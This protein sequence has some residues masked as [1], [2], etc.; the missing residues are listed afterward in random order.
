[1]GN[2]KTLQ[3]PKVLT[4]ICL[5]MIM[6]KHFQNYYFAT[7]NFAYFSS[8]VFILFHTFF[9]KVNG[10]SKAKTLSKFEANAYFSLAQ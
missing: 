7:T 10:L 1:M 8:I 5:I 3:C 4:E 9:L 6:L 2:D